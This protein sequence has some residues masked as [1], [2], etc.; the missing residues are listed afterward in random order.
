ML[1][2]TN[3]HVQRAYH[4]DEIDEKGLKIDFNYYLSSQI[5]PV[6][7]RL[8]EPIESLSAP[9]LADCLGLDSAAYRARTGQG[10]SSS[11]IGKVRQLNTDP[12]IKYANCASIPIGNIEIS[13]EK[14]NITECLENLG[15]GLK[16]NWPQ[17]LDLAFRRQVRKYVSK[18]HENNFTC[19]DVT[20]AA[21]VKA[22]YRKIEKNEVK[23]LLH[24]IFGFFLFFSMFQKVYPA[25]CQ[26][27]AEN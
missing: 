21:K 4:P 11:L 1:F 10:S 16:E 12:N 25:Q 20:C 6:I 13:L 7:S 19:D 23:F 15:D 27:A 3:A 5:H 8:C 26:P 18:F 2:T 14:S 24:T 17:M 22:M 9:E